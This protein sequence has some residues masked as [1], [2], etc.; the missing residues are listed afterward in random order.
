MSWTNPGED[1]SI[2]LQLQTETVSV[3]SYEEEFP[4][5]RHVKV[6]EE[7]GGQTLDQH[8]EGESLIQTRQL[9]MTAHLPTRLAS[10]TAFLSMANSYDCMRVRSS[11][12]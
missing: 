8:A 9:Q 4:G 12:M 11:S 6:E 2:P 10:T 7:A 5:D 1:Q 3:E